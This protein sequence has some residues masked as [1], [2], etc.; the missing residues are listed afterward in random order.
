MPRYN[1]VPTIVT[2]F[3]LRGLSDVTEAF[4]AVAEG[5][6]RLIGVRPEEARSLVKARK[7]IQ[8]RQTRG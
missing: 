5:K 8:A 2:R 6:A 1:S 7:A 3:D 4:K